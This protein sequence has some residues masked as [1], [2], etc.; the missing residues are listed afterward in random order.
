[1]SVWNKRPALRWLVPGLA[2]VL[3]V[4]GGAAASAITMQ[5]QPDLSPRSAAQLLADLHDSPVSAFSGTLVQKA[6]LG[7]PELPESSEHRGA[8]LSSLWSGSNTLRIWYDGPERVRLALLGTLSQCD[9]IRNGQDLWIW[10][11][12]RNEASHRVLPEGALAKPTGPMPATPL[13][14]AQQLLAAIEPTTEVTADTTTR[15][16]ERDAYELV[17]APRDDAS[18]IREI[19]LAIDA[20][21]KIPLSV[22]V[23]GDD[24]APA[25]EVRF[26]QISFEQPDVEQFQFNPP[27]DATVTE[28]ELLPAMP[29]L[30][31]FG[32][33][34][35]PLAVVGEG[36]TQVLVVRLPEEIVSELDPVRQLLPDGQTFAGS[37]FSAMLTDDGRLLVGA[38]DPQRLAE[39]AADP[40]A[41]VRE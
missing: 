11:S 21:Q 20:E 36:W 14:A 19:R 8:D 35:P 25:F 6:E 5:D 32:D 34:P 38:V 7:L 39:A 22:Q 31:K 9:I 1:M 16:A 28:A 24:A 27:P 26:T 12:S 2:A 4:G 18:L 37:L 23:Y 3:V 33:E 41:A 30:D 10:N 15:V 17:V 29:L 40:E 13:E